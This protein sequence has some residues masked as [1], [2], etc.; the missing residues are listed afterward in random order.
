M[1]PIKT[2]PEEEKVEYK[3]EDFQ[4]DELLANHMNKI[5]YLT[6]KDIKRKEEED[7]KKGILE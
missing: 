1:M 2:P 7:L 3:P 4:N 5:L 6:E